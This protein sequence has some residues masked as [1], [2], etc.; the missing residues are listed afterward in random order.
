MH[1]N[2]ITTWENCRRLLNIIFGT[3]TRGMGLL[4]DRVTYP[5]PHIQAYEEA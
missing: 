5:T 2:K 1:Q 3:D 4:Y